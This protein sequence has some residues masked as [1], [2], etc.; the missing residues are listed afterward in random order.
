MVYAH[1]FSIQSNAASTKTSSAR[2]NSWSSIRFKTVSGN[3]GKVGDVVI[4]C[5]VVMGVMHR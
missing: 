3:L 4:V 2:A 1:S 5:L